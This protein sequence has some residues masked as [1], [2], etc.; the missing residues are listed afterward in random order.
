[1]IPVGFNHHTVKQDWSGFESAPDIN[2]VQKEL[3]NARFQIGT[4]GGGNHF[5]EIL[6]DENA[7]IWIMVHSGSRNIGFKTANFYHRKAI[8]YC[9]EKDID[10]PTKDLAYLPTESDIGREYFEAMSYC[11][12]FARAN[13]ELM[14]NRAKQVFK[15]TLNC[16]FEPVIDAHHNFANEETHYGEKV[17][18]H[19][20]GAISAYEDEPGIVPGSMGTPSYIT[21]GLGNKESFCS[22]A[23][24]AGRR[25]GRKEAIRSLDLKEEQKRMSGILGGPRSKNEL[26]ESPSAYKDIDE[27]MSNQKDL[28]TIK[29]KLLPLSVIIG[30]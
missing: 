16:K 3:D 13:R 17:I 14:I 18:V 24:G 15:E 9:K 21:I 11:Q 28:T 30:T 8:E 5:V 22:C 29:V 10:L 25:L 27:V 2:I 19:R 6:K 12:R 7:Y 26:Q 4:L 20:K 23:H 1:M